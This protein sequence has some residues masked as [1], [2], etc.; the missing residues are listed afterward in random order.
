VPGYLHAAL[1]I[2]ALLVIGGC[3]SRAAEKRHP[4]IG[5][6]VEV[7]GERIHVLDIGPRESALSPVVLIHGA[8]VNLRDM[9]LALG[10]ELA[11]SRRVIMVD[12]PGRGYSSR[13]ADGWMLDRQARLIRDAV[14]ASGVERPIVVGQS[15]GGA[16]ALSYALQFQDEMAG[17]VLLAPVSHEWPGGVA[18]YNKVSGWPIAGL[19]FR[20]LVIPVY[21]P[22]AAKPSVE[23]SFAPDPAPPRYYEEAGVTLLFRAKDFR[24]NAEDLRKLKPQIIAMSGR[25]G[26]LKIPVAVLAGDKDRTVSP[27]IH[28][29]AL[30]NEIADVDYTVLNGT[31]H[32]LHHAQKERII[33]AINRISEQAAAPPLRQSA[34]E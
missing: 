27:K 25:Y 1:L 4:V 22:F 6:L 14:K 20:R 18:W 30:G 8:S 28:A 11:R 10:D 26:E 5:A 3:A 23:K 21:A 12:R 16:V 29:A 31:G 34:A 9:K 7:D 13:P 32:A 2:A 24:A 33:E 15:F 19:I 17:L